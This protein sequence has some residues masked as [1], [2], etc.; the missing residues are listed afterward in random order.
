[1]LKKGFFILSAFMVFLSFSC[2]GKRIGRNESAEVLYKEAMDELN[3][4]GG[5]PWIFTGSDY[6]RIFKLLKEI[7]L[8]Y[9]YSPY[10]TLAELRT[11]DAYFKKEEYEQASVE[12]EGFLKNH[13]GHPEAPYATFR[14]AL[15]HYEQRKGYDRDPTPV[16]EALKWFNLFVDKYPDSP[17]IGEAEKKMDRCRMI[18]A[19]RE[20]YIGRF[21][22]R[23]KNYKAAAERYRVVVTEYSNTKKLEEAL[24]LMGKSYYNANEMEPA[25]EAL[26]RVVNEFPKAKYHDKAAA[27]LSRIEKKE[28]REAEK[29]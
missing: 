10:A 12:Y 5:F 17:L 3:K 13:P 15:S 9:T 18:L 21:Y 29:L 6:D 14:L 19:E 8:R 4:K 20:M 7:Q 1:M 27:L 23:R 28:K 11:A 2:G 22:E 26:R 16:R 25:K 24:F